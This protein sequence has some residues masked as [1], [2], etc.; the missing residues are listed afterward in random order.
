MGPRNGSF[1]G[2]DDLG[3]RF[4]RCWRSFVGEVRGI[5]LGVLVDSMPSTENSPCIKPGGN[6]VKLT[7]LRTWKKF[8]KN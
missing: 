1:L 3:L 5:G 8:A 4:N 7:V 6:F 2:I